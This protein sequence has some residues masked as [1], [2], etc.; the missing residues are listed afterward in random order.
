[1]CGTNRTYPHTYP[2]RTHT[3]P[4]LA[5]LLVLIL[6]SVLLTSRRSSSTRALHL[7]TSAPPALLPSWLTRLNLSSSEQVDLPQRWA[8]TAC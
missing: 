1:M 3:Q 7:P 6:S 5:V 2:A 8:Q 4:H